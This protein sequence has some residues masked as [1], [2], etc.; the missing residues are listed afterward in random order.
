MW[1]RCKY[2]LRQARF[3]VGPCCR[4]RSCSHRGLFRLKKW[5][6]SFDA[7]SNKRTFLRCSRC[8]RIFWNIRLNWE[9]PGIN[10]GQFLS[11]LKNGLNARALC[12]FPGTLWC[13]WLVSTFLF[14][15]SIE[16]ESWM[17]L[18]WL[19]EWYLNIIRQPDQIKWQLSLS[20]K[21]S[22]SCTAIK[23]SQNVGIFICNVPANGLTFWLATNK[24]SQSKFF[25]FE[26]PILKAR[27]RMVD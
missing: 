25:S 19:S 2:K 6:E 5:F 13:W 3:L 18:P 23:T 11:S 22:Y 8:A 24:L 9:I 7:R 17:L 4:G 1:R 27:G 12:N 26:L 14:A 20:T 21:H 10:G 15:M 16:S